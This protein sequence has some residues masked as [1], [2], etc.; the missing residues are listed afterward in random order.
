MLK[1]LVTLTVV[2][3]FAESSRAG[4]VRIGGGTLEL[5]GSLA[6][7]NIMV[8]TRAT[9]TGSGTIDGC[10][11]LAGTIAPGN[12]GAPVGAITVSQDLICHASS[13]FVCD[14]TSHVIG[15]TLLAATASGICTVSVQQADGAIPVD[16]E[17]I[18]V[19]TGSDYAG[20]VMAE[21]QDD[22]W[23]LATEAGDLML[24]DLAGDSDGD[25]LKD[26]WEVSY[27]GG[28]TNAVPDDDADGDTAN[29]LSEQVAGTDP[30]DPKSRFALMAI[31]PSNDD[32]VVTWASVTGRVYRVNRATN[33]FGSFYP[34]ASNIVA[35]L[36]YNTY[37]DEGANNGTGHFYRI[38]IEM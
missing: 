5:N 20:F 21:A 7:G 1:T 14:V 34:I 29:N 22:D 9:L 13:H 12:S 18:T 16:L 3:L 17:I 32:I 10:L 8:S 24:T 26:W 31:T 11:D 35:V 37:R 15:D 36:P 2:A 23:R 30:E 33:L 27:F 38:E 19:N 4:T 25:L 28:R 6:S